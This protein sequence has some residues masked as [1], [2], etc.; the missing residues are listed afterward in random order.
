MI[1][2]LLRQVVLGF[3]VPLSLG[4]DLAEP[5]GSKHFQSLIGLESLESH[6]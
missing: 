3:D 6:H 4:I 1:T 5:L 2:L